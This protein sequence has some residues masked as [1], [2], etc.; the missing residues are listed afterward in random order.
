L[1][2]PTPRRKR[3]GDD[4]FFEASRA[5]VLSNGEASTELTLCPN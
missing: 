1:I 5:E 2:S 3:R 4:D